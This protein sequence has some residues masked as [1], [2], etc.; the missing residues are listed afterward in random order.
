[1]LLRIC[2]FSFFIAANVLTGE[3]C[4]KS[5]CLPTPKHYDELG[6]KPIKKSGDCCTTR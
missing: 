4:D 1:M 3:A 6:C 2:A 5:K